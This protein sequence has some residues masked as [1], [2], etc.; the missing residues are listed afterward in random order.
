MVDRIAMTIDA[1][2]ER[3]KSARG[4]IRLSAPV[5]L[6]EVFAR[7]SALLRDRHPELVLEL[8]LSAPTRPPGVGV[9][10][11][12]TLEPGY[13]AGFVG[14][15]S[16]PIPFGLYA[17]PGYVA[18]RGLVGGPGDLDGH[19]LIDF[20]SAGRHVAPASLSLA[21]QSSVDV[22][23]RSNSPSARRAAARAGLGVIM[24]PVVLGD[25]DSGLV[26]ICPPER[27]GAIT[28]WIHVATEQRGRHST[29]V[30]RDWAVES[31]ATFGSI[32]HQRSAAGEP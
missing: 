17:S 31:I 20:E 27:V 22:V 11:A 1:V 8:D 24:E 16:A 5:I 30:V 13:F 3:P 18:K 19:A 23:F 29:L 28:V 21:R 26:R 32:A 10:I 4:E 12:L 6:G 9:D 7:R 2:R 14:D 25:A 15:G